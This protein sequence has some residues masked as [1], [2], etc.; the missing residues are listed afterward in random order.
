MRKIIFAFVCSF[1]ALGWLGC[2]GNVQPAPPGFIDC[3][4]IEIDSAASCCGIDSFVIKSPWMQ[5]RINSFLADSAERKNKLYTWLEFQCFTDTLGTDY[6][7]ENKY[8]LRDCEGTLL[9]D[10]EDNQSLIDVIYHCGNFR[11]YSL[12]FMKL[13]LIPQYPDN[14]LQPDSITEE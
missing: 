12:V 2:E 5:E 13:G 4:R 3:N 11:F 14:I 7:L 10:F 8:L 1:I 6:I 9:V